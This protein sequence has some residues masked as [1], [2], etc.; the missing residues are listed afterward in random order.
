MEKEI[1][2]EIKRPEIIILLVFLSIIL[3]LKLQVTFNSPIA[4]GDEG[5][6]TR[7][8]QYMA[9]EVE[10]PVLT[11]M[12]E[13]KLNYGGFV[14]PPLFNLL[15]GSFFLLLGH[16]DSIIKF[17]TPFTTFLIGIVVYLLTKKIWNEKVGLIA[18]IFSVTIPSLVTYS[19]LFYTDTLYTLYVTLFFLLFLIAM[20][21]D[22]KKIL[23]LAGIFG[24]LAFLTDISGLAIYPFVLIGLLYELMIKKK[25]SNIIKKYTILLSI[26]ILIPSTFLIRNIYYFNNPLCRDLPL[27]NIFDNSKCSTDEFEEKYHFAGRVE[28]VGTEQSVYSMGIV[29]YLDFAYGNIWLILLGTFSGL[30]ILF[31][32]RRYV[33]SYIAIYLLLFFVMFY[34]STDRAEDTARNTLGWV[35]VFALV[36]GVYFAE[37]YNFLK[38]YQKYIAL[39]VFLAIFFFSYQNVRSKLD[40]M[41]RVKQFSPIFFE[42]CNWVKENTPKNVSL[43][44]VWGWRALYNCQRNAV[45]T[46]TIPDIALSRDVNYTVDVAK[47]HGITHIFIQKFSIDYRNQHFSENYDIDFVKFLEDNPQHF[48][49]IY[50]NGP[51]LEQCLQQGGCDGNIIYE[52]V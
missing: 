23:I 34:F 50:E 28:Q 43:Y 36:S 8:A 33:T 20:K 52:I 40:V 44:T 3:V 26:L 21:D 11:G 47:Q 45:G 24:G 48:K 46:G 25:F 1:T 17:L 32:K 35:P 31:S 42:A 30:I 51:S 2:I 49:K 10:Y 27:I 4:F 5:F 18:A 14:R 9:E 6:H 13:T 19:V 22:N 37:L 12:G 39:V 15:E 29:N 41:F 16:E 7:M 38:N